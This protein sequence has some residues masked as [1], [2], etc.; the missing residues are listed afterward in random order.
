MKRY[1]LFVL[2]LNATQGLAQNSE[3]PNSY[4]LDFTIKELEG[5]KT[6]S[7]RSYS[8]IVVPDLNTGINPVNTATIRTGSK[9]PSAA[10]GGH[11]TYIE[12]GVN[13]DVHNF[14]EMG[15]DLSMMVTADISSF[16][17]DPTSTQPVIRQNKW[18]SKLLIPIRKPTVIFSSDD[19]TSKHQM[20]MELTATPIPVPSK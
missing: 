9:V 6:L 17:P 16:V 19:L 3:P 7:S 20:Q 10:G 8:T 13:I 1:L 15:K 11:F 14:K 2:L 18:S 12:V 4:R 5:A